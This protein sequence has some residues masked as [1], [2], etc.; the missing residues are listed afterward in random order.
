MQTEDM[1][2]FDSRKEL[3]RITRQLYSVS[4][5]INTGLGSASS[6]VKLSVKLLEAH[7]QFCQRTG[8]GGPG[9][10]VTRTHTA[11]QYVH[12]AYL[13][14]QSW[15]EQYKTRKE[16]AMGFVSLLPHK[17]EAWLTMDRCSTWSRKGTAL[18]L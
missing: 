11:L 8:R 10:S 18:L 16:T 15:L 7:T 6:A 12:D 1:H 4:Q 2:D 14:Q 3:S 5:M 17:L 13:Y 9:T